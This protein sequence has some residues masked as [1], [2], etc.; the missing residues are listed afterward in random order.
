M[1]ELAEKSPEVVDERLICYEECY[2]YIF[3]TVRFLY[4]F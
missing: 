1:N 4:N 3:N 2:E